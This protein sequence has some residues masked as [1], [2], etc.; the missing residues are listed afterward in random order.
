MIPTLSYYSILLVVGYAPVVSSKTIP[1]K[2]TPIGVR[3]PQKKPIQPAVWIFQPGNH[4]V[5][6]Q[7]KQWIESNLLW[8]ID[9]AEHPPTRTEKAPLVGVFA[10]A[11]VWPLG[12]RS[13]VAALESAGID[14]EVLDRSRLKN[15]N[16]ARYAAV[17]FPGGY[18]YF[19][20]L[21]AGPLG[22]RAIKEYVESGGR[23]LGICAGGFLAAKDVHW[24]GVNYPYPLQLFDGVAQGSIKEIAAWPKAGRAKLRL[25]PAGEKAGLSAADGE[26]IYYQGGCRFVGGTKVV[27]LAK[28]SDDTAAIIQRPFG[29]DGKGMVILSGVHFERPAPVDGKSTESEPPPALSIQIFPK[30]LGVAT[31]KIPSRKSSFDAKKYAATVTATTTEDEW[32]ALQKPLRTRLAELHAGNR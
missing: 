9:L 32:L 22:L 28:Y 4:V 25:T 10:D 16:L 26:E 1:A 24:E 18:S 20:Q 15:D 5:D 21:S 12:A 19:Q 29:K 31:P 8:M 14:C 7:Y 23:Y 17:I 30:L 6:L 11:G 2:H 27:T 13:V 3:V